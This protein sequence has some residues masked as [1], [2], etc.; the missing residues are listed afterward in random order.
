M[1]VLGCG[2]SDICWMDLDLSNCYFIRR[3]GLIVLFSLQFSVH[4]LYR[5]DSAGDTCALGEQVHQE[6]RLHD[7]YWIRNIV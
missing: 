6:F 1:F 7:S 5:I 3:Q 4:L 2:S